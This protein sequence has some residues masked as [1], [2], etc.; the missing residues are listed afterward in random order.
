MLKRNSGNII[1]NIVERS[2]IL[3]Y[4]KVIRVYGKQINIK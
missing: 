4:V 3:D 1:G 2:E